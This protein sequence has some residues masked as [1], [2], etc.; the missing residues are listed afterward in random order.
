MN[1]FLAAIIGGIV[2]FLIG[3]FGKCASGACPMT[4]N[5]IIST[6]IGAL[7]GAMLAS[8]K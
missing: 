8:S 7:I 1:I 2:G 4:S 6:I 5:P 3:H